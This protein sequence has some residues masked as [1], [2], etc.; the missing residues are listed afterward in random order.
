MSFFKQNSNAK[1]MNE[2]S[3]NINTIKANNL[4]DVSI[5]S[6]KVNKILSLDKNDLQALNIL[7]TK[8]I[9][10]LNYYSEVLLMKKAL[11]WIFND[12]E[13]DY[14]K[15]ISISINCCNIY[16]INTFREWINIW[17]GTESNN[18]SNNESSESKVLNYFNKEIYSIFDNL[19]KC[20]YT[21]N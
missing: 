4:S 18:G 17:F 6:S 10:I 14:H 19:K 2:L 3:F 13:T 7:K 8:N 1:R 11:D 16:C 9:T 20:K 15:Y 21:V 12:T 5:K